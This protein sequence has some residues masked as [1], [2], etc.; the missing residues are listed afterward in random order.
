LQALVQLATLTCVIVSTGNPHRA[1][2]DAAF[3]ITFHVLD[4]DARESHDVSS[5]CAPV[6]AITTIDAF[7]G[8]KLPAHIANCPPSPMFIEPGTCAAPKSA[9]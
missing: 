6:S 4:P 5:T 1:N 3:E 2:S 9:R 7:N 8:I